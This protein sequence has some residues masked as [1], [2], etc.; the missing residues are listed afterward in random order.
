[1]QCRAYALALY[2]GQRLSDLVL[3]MRAHRH[4]GLVHVAAQGK[5]G[6]ELWIPE[7]SEL[8]AELARGVAIASLLTTPTQGKPFDP[9]YF[10]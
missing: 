9:V 6:E 8:T 5:T 10:G 7:H 2:S 3:M 4:E 1:M